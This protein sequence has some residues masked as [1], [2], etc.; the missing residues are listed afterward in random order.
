MEIDW[1][2]VLSDVDWVEFEYASRKF[3]AGY[4]ILEGAQGKAIELNIGSDA[5]TIDGWVGLQWCESSGLT[6]DWPPEGMILN[7]LKESDKQPQAVQPEK[8]KPIKA[9]KK[10]VLIHP[11]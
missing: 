5:P 9:I 3:R 10:D 1:D 7:K 8:P 11:R 4:Y 2:R 6:N